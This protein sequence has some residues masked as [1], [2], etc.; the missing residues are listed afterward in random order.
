MRSVV[1]NSKVNVDLEIVSSKVKILGNKK[2]RKLR[3]AT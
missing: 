1:L 2:E 3:V